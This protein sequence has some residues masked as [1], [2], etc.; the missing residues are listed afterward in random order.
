MG[1]PVSDSV[2]FGLF[3]AS[4]K[5]LVW[6]TST[7]MDKFY[8]LKP[9]PPPPALVMPTL[10]TNIRPALSVVSRPLQICSPMALLTTFS[11]CYP[12]SPSSFTSFWTIFSN[13]FSSAL[14]PVLCEW[15]HDPT[16]VI[17]TELL[18]LC[19]YPK[20]PSPISKLLALSSVNFILPLSHTSTTLVL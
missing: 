18:S 3:L 5:I 7:P 19:R 4:A 2:G 11:L 8:L 9:P 13:A 6:R 10:T 14:C 15:P 1:Q 17:A 12:S 20:L 16:L